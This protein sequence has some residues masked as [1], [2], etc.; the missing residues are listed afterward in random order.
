MFWFMECK[1]NWGTFVS[2]LN[3]NLARTFSKRW[4][5]NQMLTLAT[6]CV[7]AVLSATS[8][9]ITVL[10]HLFG[11]SGFTCDLHCS[12]LSHTLLTLLLFPLRRSI[13]C[14]YF[15]LWWR[16]LAHIFCRSFSCHSG[17]RSSIQSF[18]IK[19]ICLMSFILKCCCKSHCWCL[20]EAP[21]DSEPV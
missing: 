18:I 12:S 16:Y 3:I 11:L 20:S 8:S 21:E 13:T 9:T 6:R 10:H 2:T 7:L 15:S 1:D 5:E 14:F 17:Y 4:Q 19:S